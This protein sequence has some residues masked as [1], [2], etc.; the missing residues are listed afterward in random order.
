M[1]IVTHGGVPHENRVLHLY[2]TVSEQIA[3][4]VRHTCA[5]ALSEGVLGDLSPH[6]LY[7]L[8]RSVPVTSAQ[9]TMLLSVCCTSGRGLRLS[10]AVR[11]RSVVPHLDHRV[12]L[13]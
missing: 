6:T 13:K 10:F 5:S 9:E 4:C 2:G 3:V 12:A 11:L 1:C 7:H 8:S